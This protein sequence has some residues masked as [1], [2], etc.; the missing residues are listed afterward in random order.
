[1]TYQVPQDKPTPVP[2]MEPVLSS[3]LSW[4]RPAVQSC[5]PSLSPLEAAWALNLLCNVA[6]KCFTFSGVEQDKSPLG[7]SSKQ[8]TRPTLWAVAPWWPAVLA[9]A[10]LFLLAGRQ[11]LGQILTF[12]A[13]LLLSSLQPITFVSILLELMLCGSNYP[14]GIC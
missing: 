10:S 6:A 14:L 8:R 9:W 13:G 1:M 7:L 2:V 5:H 4:R 12:L 3:P 11:D